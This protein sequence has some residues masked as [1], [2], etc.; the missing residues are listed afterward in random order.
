M[1][2]IFKLLLG[3]PPSISVGSAGAARDA[4]QARD[5]H[6]LVHGVDVVTSP[7]GKASL[8]ETFL[9]QCLVRSLVRSL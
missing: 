4:A 3:N 1:A 2:C 9:S 6:S 7:V 5:L 8:P